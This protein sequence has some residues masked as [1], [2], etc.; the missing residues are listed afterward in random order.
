[1][2]SS[3]PGAARRRVAVALAL[4]GLALAVPPPALAIDDDFTE[5]MKALD[6]IRVTSFT[7]SPSTIG[8]FGSSQLGWSVRGRDDLIDLELNGD[9]VPFRGSLVVRPR[10]TTTYTLV[11]KAYSRRVAIGGVTVTVDR[12]ACNTVALNGAETLME[13]VLLQGIEAPIYLRGGRAPDVTFEPGYVRIR[14]WLGKDINNRPDPKIDIDARFS[15]DL[16]RDGRLRPGRMI[17]GASASLPAW[18][19]WYPGVEAQLRAGERDARAKTIAGIRD[20]VRLLDFYYSADSGMRIQD[21]AIDSSGIRFTQCP[22]PRAND[23]PPTGP[24]TE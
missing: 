11:A 23:V 1:M 4:L 3:L 13:G 24:I 21:V 9:P 16:D 5:A 8:P 14:M 20:L 19:D 18:A 10:A 12:S 22:I 17:V 15:L 6:D 7:R 2:T